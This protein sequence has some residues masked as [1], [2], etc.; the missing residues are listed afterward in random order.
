MYCT[1][2]FMIDFR[3]TGTSLNVLIVMVPAAHLWRPYWVRDLVGKLFTL[4]PLI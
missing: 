3:N 4:K 2:Y 1:N